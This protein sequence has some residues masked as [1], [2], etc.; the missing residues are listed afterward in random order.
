MIDPKPWWHLGFG[1][2]E[3]DEIEADSS[4]MGLT[5]SASA[6]ALLSMSLF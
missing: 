4:H 2:D 6:A 5:V 1:D 3:T